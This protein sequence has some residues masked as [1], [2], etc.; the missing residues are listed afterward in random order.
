VG[1]GFESGELP[2]GTDA[3]GALVVATAARS[4][5]H[6]LEIRARGGEAYLRW[7]ADVLG[8][9]APYWSF[10]AWVRILDWTDRESVDLFTVRNRE[11]VNNFDLF[12]GAPTRRFQWDIFRRDFGEAA[13][14]LVPG[15]WHLVEARGSFAGSTFTAEVR[16][17]GVAQ[18]PVAS[19]GQVPSAVSEF[20]L[21]S[22]GTSKTNTAQFDDVAVAVGD[23]PLPF[24]ADP[25]RP[26]DPVG[27]AASGVQP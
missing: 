5:A 15:A 24:P 14:G 9:P 27:A 8:G 7:D 12:V 1:T 6:G 21:G 2:A 26:D 22:I 19:T 23:A 4:G 3:G 18:T 16:I 13:G 17:D 11:V 10:R 25:A 20:V